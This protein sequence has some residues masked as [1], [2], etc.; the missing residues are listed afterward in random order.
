LGGTVSAIN[1]DGQ[2]VQNTTGSTINL[3]PN[4]TMQITYTVL[5]TVLKKK[6]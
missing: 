1:I 2:T 4:E 5:P 6:G 3:V